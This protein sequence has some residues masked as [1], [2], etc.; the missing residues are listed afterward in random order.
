MEKTKCLHCGNVRV[1]INRKYHLCNNCNWKRLHPG[2][3]K[4]VYQLKRTPL[5]R[6]RSKI[7]KI[8][9]EN[10]YKTSS[11]MLVSQ[12]YIDDM[13]RNVCQ[14]I[15]HERYKMCQGTHR[16]DLPLSFSHTISRQRCKDLGKA[17]LIWDS[18]N[19]ELESFEAPTSKPTAAHNIWESGTIEQKRSLFN[20]ERKMNYLK[21]HDYE[22]W[23]RLK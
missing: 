16:V 15:V 5:K 10:K 2:E 23:K 12:S 22:T 4:K 19:I 17:E 21:K 18:E 6:G 3:K 1:I 7:K 11:G 13:Y 9:D 8:S 20:F 14:K